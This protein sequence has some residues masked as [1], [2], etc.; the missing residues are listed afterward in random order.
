MRK[1]M[2]INKKTILVITVIIVLLIGYYIY[3]K[4]TN[5]YKEFEMSSNLEELLPYEEDKTGKN[6]EVR[7]QQIEKEN[8]DVI[9]EQEIIIVHVTGEVNSPGVV[10]VEKGARVIDAVNK[11]QGFTQ[12][13]DTEK[14]N[15]AYELTDGVKIYIPSKSKDK[16]NNLSTQKYITTDSGDN[17]DTEE[18]NMKNT[19]SSLVNINEATQTELET[20]PGIGPSI[21]LKIISYRKE[22]GKF[23]SKE[24][25]K[26]VSGIGDSKFESIRELICL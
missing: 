1:R 20:L 3:Y 24:E 16:E 25:I 11:A 17:V 21:A 26:N 14:V 9:S 7:E 4:N 18:K 22:K 8:K 23:S 15:L 13:A 19:T 5:I 6:E 2:D 10:E 12:D